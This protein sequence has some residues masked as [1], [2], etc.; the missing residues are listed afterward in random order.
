MRET[1]GVADTSEL[2]DLPQAVPEAGPATAILEQCPIGVAIVGPD[3]GIRY[4]NAHFAQM[5]GIAPARRAWPPLDR[6]LPDPE[7]VSR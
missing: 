3:L 5:A 2:I 1:G 6:F 7:E 4:G